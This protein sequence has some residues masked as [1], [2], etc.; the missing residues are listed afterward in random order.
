MGATAD[1]HLEEVTE[2]ILIHVLDNVDKE[3]IVAD[4]LAE[5]PRHL[6]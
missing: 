6:Q 3:V 2:M 4:T 5:M 1:V